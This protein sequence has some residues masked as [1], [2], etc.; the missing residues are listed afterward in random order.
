MKHFPKSLTNDKGTKEQIELYI[1]KDQ[2]KR[3]ELENQ[4]AK[5]SPLGTLTIDKEYA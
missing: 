3:R 4:V 2:E 1:Q 5:N